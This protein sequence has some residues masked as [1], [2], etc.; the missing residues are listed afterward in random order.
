[1]HRYTC[2]Q[3]R[4]QVVLLLDSQSISAILATFAACCNQFVLVLG[5]QRQDTITC[6]SHPGSADVIMRANKP[7]GRLRQPLSSGAAQREVVAAGAWAFRAAS[8]QHQLRM[9]R[10]GNH[11]YASGT[12]L[13]RKGY[14]FGTQMVRMILSWYA[15]HLFGTH[16]IRI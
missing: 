6:T 7:G 12:H 14:A 8:S 10:S 3:L 5:L 15:L 2:L 11:W 1:M 4:H 13:L 9:I 16:T